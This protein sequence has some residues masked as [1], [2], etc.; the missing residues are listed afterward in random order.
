MHFSNPNILLFAASLLPSFAAAQLSGPVGPLTTR[1]AK[2]SKVCSVLD[3]GGIADK[4]GDIGPALVKAFEACKT[5]GTGTLD[6]LES[7]NSVETGR[8][9][10]E[11]IQVFELMLVVYVPPGDYGM[12]TW[13]SL[14]GGS[15]WALQLDGIIYRVGYSNHP[16]SFLES[17]LT[18]P[19][20]SFR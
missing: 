6:Y 1:E 20:V 9:I 4:K 16:L 17:R 7:S 11:F 19:Q 5:G 15:A 3:Y 18:R 10:L 12:S 8:G 2:R 13:A 14:V